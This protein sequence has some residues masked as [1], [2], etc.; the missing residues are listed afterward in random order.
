MFHRGYRLA[1][2]ES[3]KST[4]AFL[5]RS[6]DPQ[7]KETVDYFDR[8]RKKRHRFIYDEVGLVS[9]KEVQQLIQIATEFIAWVD[10]KLKTN[11]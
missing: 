7:Q 1:S 11:S 6:V 2:A 3:D 8:V 9:E 5:Q 4:S 10:M